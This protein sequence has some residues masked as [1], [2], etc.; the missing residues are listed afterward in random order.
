MIDEQKEEVKERVI[1]DDVRRYRIRD[2]YMRGRDP[3]RDHRDEDMPLSIDEIRQI[4]RT[5]RE[6]QRAGGLNIR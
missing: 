6:L 5:R 4:E 2:E 1:E 3:H